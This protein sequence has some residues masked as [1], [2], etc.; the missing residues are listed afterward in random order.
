[1]GRLPAG[2]RHSCH[3]DTGA[4]VHPKVVS[5]RLGHASIGVTLD[6]ASHVM[7]GMHK[8]AAEKLDAGLRAALAT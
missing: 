5:E 8:E 3:R 1:L 6:S 2:T 4:G 7:P